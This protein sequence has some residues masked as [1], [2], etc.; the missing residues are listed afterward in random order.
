[1]LS[2][3]LLRQLAHRNEAFYLPLVETQCNGKIG[4]RMIHGQNALVSIQKHHDDEGRNNLI[5][6]QEI[7]YYTFM[8]S[9]V[10]EPPSKGWT[11]K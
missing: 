4:N 7:I 6:I 3:K 10:Y 11:I 8:S 9:K 5:A 1:M 2:Y